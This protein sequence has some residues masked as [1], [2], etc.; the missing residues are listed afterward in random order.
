M[1]QRE[2]YDLGFNSYVGV[3]S[4]SVMVDNCSDDIACNSLWSCAEGIN[5]YMMVCSA[6]VQEE[7]S[8]NTMTRTGDSSFRQAPLNFIHIHS[9]ARSNRSK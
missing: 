2:G 4:S 8:N 3:A 5:A 9:G 1:E 7:T 6:R